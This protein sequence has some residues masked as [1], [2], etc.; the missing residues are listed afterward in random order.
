MGVKV[1]D[2]QGLHAVKQIVTQAAHGA[3]TDGNHDAVI[4]I[5][6]YYAQY[7]QTAE[8]NHRLP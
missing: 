5:G 8:P 3:L 2:G 1:F 7:Q 4:A 6:G